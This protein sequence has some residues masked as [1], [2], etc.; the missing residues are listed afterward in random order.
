MNPDIATTAVGAPPQLPPDDGRRTPA[1]RMA[2]LESFV[3]EDLTPVDNIFIEKQDR[4]LTETLNGSWE[5]P[6][7]GRA[8]Q[9]FADVGLFHE[10][11]LDGLAPDIMLAVDIP[12]GGDLSLRPNRSYF[13]WLRGKAPDVVVEFVSDR[14][15]REEDFKFEA[16]AQIGVRYYVIF[17]PRNRLRHGVLRGFARNGDA[18]HP[19]TELWLPDVNLGLTLWQGIYEKHEERWLRWLGREGKLI[20]TGAERADGE[21]QRADDEARKRRLLEERLCALGIDFENLP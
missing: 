2:D 9:A 14:R 13:T 6:G 4:L 20:P 11:F 18:F 12:V 15:G 8:F 5:G 17:D 21:R 16:Y 10:D 1:A 3:I 7:P 19:L